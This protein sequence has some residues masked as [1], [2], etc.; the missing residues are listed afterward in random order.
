LQEGKLDAVPLYINAK[1]SLCC[2]FTMESNLLILKLFDEFCY[3]LVASAIDQYI[4]G[5]NNDYQR[6]A[7]EQAGEIF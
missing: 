1:I 5:I 4:L 2:P 3:V 6:G 7:H